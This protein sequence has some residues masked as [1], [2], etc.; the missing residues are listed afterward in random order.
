MQ[1]DHHWAIGRTSGNGVQ[2]QAFAG[3]GEGVLLC[4]GWSQ[5]ISAVESP[6]KSSWGTCV[7]A[8]N[9]PL[10]AGRSETKTRS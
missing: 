3:E 6:A 10:P 9:T 7:N 1:E 5:G 2:A 8:V 4:H